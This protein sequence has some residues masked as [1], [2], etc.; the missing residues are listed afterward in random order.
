MRSE[1]F[2]SKLK[3]RTTRARRDLA[4]SPISL[5]PT[6]VDAALADESMPMVTK[7]GSRRDPAETVFAAPGAANANDLSDSVLLESLAEQ[8]NLLQEQQQ[9]IRQLLDRAGTRID[10]PNA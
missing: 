8:L 2:E 1:L 6:A 5:E 10:A 9:Q 3:S 4:R 7:R